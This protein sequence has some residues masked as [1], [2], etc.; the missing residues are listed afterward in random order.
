[1]PAGRQ[2]RRREIDSS[3]IIR[4]LSDT[5]TMEQAASIVGCSAPAIAARAKQDVEVKQAIRDQERSREDDLAQAIMDCKGILTKVA[6]RVGLGSGAA[7]RH[8]IARNP[9]LREVF[10]SARE[11]VIDTAED[12]VFQAVEEGN[13]AYS[14]KVLQ[15]LGKDRGYTERREVEQQHVHSVDQASTD[16]LIEALNAAAAMPEAIEA[17]FRELSPESHS[18]V[19]EALAEAAPQSADDDSSD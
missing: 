13:L 16:K 8:H 15:T 6:E 14:W 11:R 5:R 3:I 18:L 9:R 17:E 4:A 19:M 7:V 12:N 2:G 1:M 10:N